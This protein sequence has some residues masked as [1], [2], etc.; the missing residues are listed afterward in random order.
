MCTKYE[1]SFKKPAVA[2]KK[3]PNFSSRNGVVLKK[4]IYH[5]TTS[6]SVD[7]VISWLCNPAA[8]VSAHYVIARDGAITQLVKDGDRAWH[9]YQNNADSI[10]IEVCA[11]KGQKM[12]PAQDKALEGLSKFLLSEYPTIE[13]VTG[14]RFLY[15]D[16]GYT[17]CPGSIFAD[18]TIDALRVWVSQKLIADFPKLRLPS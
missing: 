17:D 4:I 1:K 5:Y 12:T 16:D 10:G 3:S 11:E 13:T 9:A 7:G 2:W 6:N 8:S 14:H 18:N 15:P